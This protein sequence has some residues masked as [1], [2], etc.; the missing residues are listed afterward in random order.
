MLWLTVKKVIVR[1][2]ITAQSDV[3]MPIF[4]GS[5]K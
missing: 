4:R 3:T 2:G 1:D 5:K